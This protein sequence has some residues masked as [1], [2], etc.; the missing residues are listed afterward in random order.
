[1]SNE[2]RPAEAMKDLLAESGINEGQPLP[3][4]AFEDMAVT[5]VT[6]SPAPVLQGVLGNLTR[7]LQQK[8]E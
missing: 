4:Q 3:H 1:M 8:P 5:V 7:Q 6:E 2:N